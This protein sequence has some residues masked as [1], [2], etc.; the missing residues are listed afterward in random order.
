MSCEK[1]IAGTTI[2]I[3]H[4]LC[5]DSHSIFT[6][7]R[8]IMQIG[9]TTNAN[10]SQQTCKLCPSCVFRRE[11]LNKELKDNIS[12]VND[13]FFFRLKKLYFSFTKINT[14]VSLAEKLIH[15]TELHT[16]NHWR[17]YYITFDLPQL[18]FVHSCV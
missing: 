15:C 3:Q 7:F 17:I 16:A 13:N 18:Q 5:Q 2:A 14:R 10:V 12:Y 4:L 11:A 9:W 6:M 8:W 1:A